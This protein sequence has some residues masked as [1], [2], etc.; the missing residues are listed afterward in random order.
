VGRGVDER[1]PVAE[2]FFADIQQ[3]PGRGVF[4][5]PRLKVVFE[6][7]EDAAGLW[8]ERMAFR[9][10]GKFIGKGGATGQR[11]RNSEQENEVSACYHEAISSRPAR[12]ASA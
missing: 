6:V 10:F 4:R 1:E 12:T 5:K 9:P 2:S 7:R 8:G 11:N 3:V